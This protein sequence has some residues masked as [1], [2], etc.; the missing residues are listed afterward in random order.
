M[1][2]LKVLVQDPIIQFAVLVALA[3][4]ARF[5]TRRHSATRFFANVVSFVLLTVLLVAN[6]VAPWNGDRS[7]EDLTHRIFIGLAK[8]T[9]WVGGA[10]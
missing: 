1:V 4:M 5:Q 3:L 6:N 10:V 7:A 2:G 9:W 8:A